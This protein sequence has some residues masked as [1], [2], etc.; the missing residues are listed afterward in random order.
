M[1]NPPDHLKHAQR[2]RGI[3]V[4]RQRD[5]LNFRNEKPGWKLASQFIGELKFI[6]AAGSGAVYWIGRA[7]GWW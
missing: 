1:E 7:T 6:L 3:P 2:S 5:P 4:L